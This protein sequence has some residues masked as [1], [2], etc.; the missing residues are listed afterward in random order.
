M[1]SH[2]WFFNGVCQE[3]QPEYVILLNAGTAPEKNALYKMIY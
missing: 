2:N 1:S 3:L